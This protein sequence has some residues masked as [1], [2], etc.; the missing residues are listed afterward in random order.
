MECCR[1]EKEI[2]GKWM[3]EEVGICE[4][5]PVEYM[6]VTWCRACWVEERRFWGETEELEA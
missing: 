4:G 6:T 3:Q 5:P 1:C 2:V